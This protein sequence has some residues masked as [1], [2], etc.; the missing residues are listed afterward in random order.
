LTTAAAV[1]ATII[2]AALVRT[3]TAATAATGEDHVGSYDL[4]PVALISIAVLVARGADASLDK[5]AGALGQ[6]LAE[7]VSPL[8]PK[9][10][11]MPFGSLLAHPIAIEEA[12][13]RGE[14]HLQD[15]LPAARHPEFRIGAEITKQHYAI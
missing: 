2:V 11:V 13:R 14:S 7:S 15:R 3:A 9:S 10:H 1:A 12:L 4:C 8:P 6:E 5:H